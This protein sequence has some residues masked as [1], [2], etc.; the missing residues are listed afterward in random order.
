M[1]FHLWNMLANLKNGQLSKK[2][3]ILQKKTILCSKI[4]N[5]L[6]DE[7]YILGYKIYSENSDFFIIFLKYYKNVPCINNIHG[8]SKPSCRIYLSTKNIWKIEN[9][10]GLFILSTNKGILSSRTC[11]RFNIGGELLI[12]L[13]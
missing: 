4:L 7:G 8:I 11:K 10:I 5:L 12:Y 6:W 2:T 3:Y 9:E 13:N 1:N